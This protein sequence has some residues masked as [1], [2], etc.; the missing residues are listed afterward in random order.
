M[1]FLHLEIECL[2]FRLLA[3]LNHQ[4]HLEAYPSRLSAGRIDH[5]MHLDLGRSSL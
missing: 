3:N 1:K 2:L 5:Q 4:D